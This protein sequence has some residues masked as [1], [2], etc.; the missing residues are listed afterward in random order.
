MVN[1]S[2]FRETAQL[3]YGRNSPE[4]IMPSNSWA[5]H[6]GMGKTSHFVK[7]STSMD[8]GNCERR[9]TVSKIHTGFLVLGLSRAT[10]PPVKTDLSFLIIPLRAAV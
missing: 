10:E 1:V 3:G 7:F 8:L 6:R 9:R 5:N 4:L 2:L